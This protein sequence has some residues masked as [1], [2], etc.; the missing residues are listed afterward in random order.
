MEPLEDV[1]RKVEDLKRALS[2][3]I[4]VQE[5]AILQHEEGHWEHVGIQELYS[6]KGYIDDH[7]EWTIDKPEITQ[8]RIAHPDTQKREAA[9]QALQQIY[10]SSEWYSVRYVAG[11]ALNLPADTNVGYWLMQLEEEIKAVK[12]G[13]EY[14]D[15]LE[16][17]QHLDWFECIGTTTIESRCTRRDIKKSLHA[18]EDIENLFKISQIGAVRTL[19]RKAYRGRINPKKCPVDGAASFCTSPYEEKL[20]ITRAGKTLGYSSLRIAL[21]YPSLKLWADKS[22]RRT[23]FVTGIATV[24]A[25]SGLGYL[26]YEYF[27]K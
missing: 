14:S 13:T 8:P 17:E 10:E 18:I 1:L 15:V 23:A 9:R 11:R 5:R 25:V 3:E 27:N 7:D 20:V 2:V 22:P 4:V 26:V 24:G 16:Y 21:S 6:S 19:L 12:T